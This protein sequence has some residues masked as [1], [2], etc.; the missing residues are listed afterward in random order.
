MRQLAARR[1]C[2]A[3]RSLTVNFTGV[4]GT[5]P[6][7]SWFSPAHP[8]AGLTSLSIKSPGPLPAAMNGLRAPDLLSFAAPPVILAGGVVFKP[9]SQH[10]SR[11]VTPEITAMYEGLRT[12][13]CPKLPPLTEQSGAAAGPNG[14]G[15]AGG[16]GGAGGD[17][18]G[19]A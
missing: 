8:W 17:E 2:P 19:A 10:D 15:G 5:A 14:T 12:G 6:E 13:G 16:S 9:V 1:L 3:L 7:P 4:G 11:R 18:E